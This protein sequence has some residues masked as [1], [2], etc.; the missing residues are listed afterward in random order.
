MAV[1]HLSREKRDLV[2]EALRAT[3]AADE[4]VAFAFLHGSFLLAAPF[5]DVD[6]AVYFA[7]GV[8][9]PDERSLLLGEHLSRLVGLPVD[10]RPLSTAPLTF[11][12]HAVRGQ[13]LTV[14]D[15]ALLSDVLEDTMRRYFDVAPVMVRATRE[16][17]SS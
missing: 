9:H 13:L 14:S 10:V 4:D 17:F 16:A 6:L 1:H 12:F 15:E 11:R 7:P 8:D 2:A 3:L 5:R